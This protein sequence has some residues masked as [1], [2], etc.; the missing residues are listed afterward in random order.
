MH[1]SHNDFSTLLDLISGGR[2]AKLDL[3]SSSSRMM[4][5]RGKV[6]ATMLGRE[7]QWADFSK[8]FAD[9]SSLMQRWCSNKDLLQQIVSGDTSN[10]SL[11]RAC[12]LLTLNDTL[13][14]D[15]FF[16]QTLSARLKYFFAKTVEPVLC[17]IVNASC[18]G[19]REH[20]VGFYILAREVLLAARDGRADVVD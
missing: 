17:P 19:P 6:V 9:I 11:D 3:L 4:C 16:G 5:Q 8:S 13:M 15:A 2:L 10:L 18:E 7:I 12:E 14:V 20:V 1:M